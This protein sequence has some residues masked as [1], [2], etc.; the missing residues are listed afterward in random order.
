MVIGKKDGLIFVILADDEYLPEKFNVDTVVAFRQG[1]STGRDLKIVKEAGK[2][3]DPSLLRPRAEDPCNYSGDG[4]PL[5][6]HA[7]GTFWYYD[8]TW[9]FENG[10]FD[11]RVE[12]N[13]SLE[14]YCKEILES[15]EKDL[16]AAEICDSL[17]LENETPKQT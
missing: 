7:D 8:E 4:N 1:P 15:R 17:G 9:A 2:M 5:H 11:T 6:E 14:S 10:P 13:A 3:A 12:A 16:T